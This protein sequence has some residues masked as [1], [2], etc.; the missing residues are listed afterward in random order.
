M[1]CAVA[2]NHKVSKIC[3]ESEHEHAECALPSVPNRPLDQ[4]IDPGRESLIRYIEK[5]WVNNTVLHYF[6]FSAPDNWRANDAQKDVVRN[7]FNEWKALGIGIEFVEVT[8]AAEAEIRIGFEQ[9][10]SWSYVGRDAID[11]VRS[12][13]DRTMN[14]GW[15]LTTAFGKDTALHEIGHA[16]GFSHEHQNPNTGIVWDVDAVNQYFSGP[17]NN[18]DEDTIYYNILRKVSLSEVNGSSWDKDSIMHYSFNKGLIQRPVV[19]QNNPLIPEAGLSPIDKSEVLKFYPGRSEEVIPG[20]QPFLSQI[21]SLQAGEQVDYLI[22]PEISRTYTLQTFGAMDSVL[23]LYEDD[24][25]N[26]VYLAG[27]DD[28]GTNNNSKITHR[29]IS[30]R[31]YYIRLRLY[32]STGTGQGGI[33]CW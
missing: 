29:L 1:R 11:L 20:L 3:T 4:H 12:I 16:L 5:K 21:V 26:P 23:V 8:N 7:S 28:S 14:F 30:G 32:Y 10:G 25:S 19:Y 6:F 18:W 2:K 31:T 13:E 27:D 9:G 24:N 33:M 15:D 17:P 22:K